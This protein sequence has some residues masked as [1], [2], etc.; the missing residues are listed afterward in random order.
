M[1]IFDCEIKKMI[2]GRNDRVVEG[3]Q[4]CQ[5]WSDYAGMG[6]GSGLCI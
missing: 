6:V 2:L 1:I 5:G 3:L 4:Y